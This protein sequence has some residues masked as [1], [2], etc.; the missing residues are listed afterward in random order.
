[1]RWP[2]KRAKRPKKLQTPDDQMTLT[3]HL[4]E[5]RMRIIRAALAVLIGFVFTLA[6]YSPILELI[7]QPFID[8][9]TANAKLD[10]AKLA[11]PELEGA[12]FVCDGTL[13]YFGPLEGFGTRIRLAS[14]GGFI[15]GLPVILWQLWKFIVP[16]L[17]ARERRY[18]IPFIVS[19]VFL[20][21]LGGSIAFWT[22]PK[23]LEF[24]FE[25]AG[26]GTTPL[27]G[28]AEYVR[29]VALMII[30]FG[31]GLEF[32]IL[33]VF[34][35]LAGVLSYRTLLKQWRYAIVGIVLLAALITPSGDP[36]SLL[37][38]SG[39]MLVSY[40]IAALIGRRI[41]RRREAAAAAE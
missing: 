23:A 8:I 33:L 24:L 15:L 17:H 7:R 12:K 13:N 38:L 4:A 29:L 22:L 28:V 16:G 37:A 21:F 5:L 19:A 26:E 34:L 31:I 30:A 3:E 25:F 2:W 40:F 32:P 11:N 9:C 35:Q 1:M 27:L 41:T 10:A 6:F 14:Y 18:A 36:I 20:F 39:P